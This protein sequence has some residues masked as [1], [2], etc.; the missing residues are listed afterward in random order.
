MCLNPLSY[1]YS[2][3]MGNIIC[4]RMSQMRYA[5]SPPTP[6]HKVENET[7]GSINM[8]GRPTIHITVWGWLLE[9]AT[10]LSRWYIW[11]GVMF[12]NLVI[13]IDI[14]PPTPFSLLLGGKGENIIL[15]CGL[16]SS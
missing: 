16:S 3:Q 12:L 10:I 4:I 9:Y 14:A 13:Y 7:L 5:S 1:A 6:L 15:N 8:L 11:H 2:K